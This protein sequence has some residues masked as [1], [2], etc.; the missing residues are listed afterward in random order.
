MDPRFRL[1]VLR[2]F[3]RQSGGRRTVGNRTVGNWRVFLADTGAAVL[4][5]SPGMALMGLLAFVATKRLDAPLAWVGIIGSSGYFGYLWNSLFSTLTSKLSLRRSIVVIMLASGVLL[6]GG[7]LQRAYLPYCLIVVVFLLVLGLFEVQYNTLVYYLY[8]SDIRSKRLSQRHLATALAWMVLSALFGRISAGSRGHLPA[9]LLAGTMM[10]AGA[11]VFRGVRTRVD[12]RMK[13]F[14]PWDIVGAIFRDPRFVRVAGI[15]TLYGWVGAGVGT[16]LVV[17]YKQA[18]FD[19]WQVGVLK[20]TMTAGTILATLTITPMLN[21]R[22]G[23]SNFRLCFSATCATIIIFLAISVARIG[24]QAFWAYAL[25]NL[26]FGVA[27]AGFT[28]ATQ[29]TAINLAPEG[30]V[31]IYVNG[32]MIVQGARG[33]L[34]PVLVAAVLEA[35]GMRVSLCIAAAVSLVCVLIVWLPGIDGELRKPL[36][37]RK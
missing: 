7:A 9:F 27:N 16:L 34:A 18:G 17:L 12:H 37:P 2:H 11:F 20:A 14:R 36:A 19:E 4:Y 1:P 8:G 23:I 29:T 26:V 3:G 31:T 13:P 10:I 35:L 24:G 30:Q 6:Y 15:L 25:A 21:F 28:L 33:I 22:G 5:Q 32:L